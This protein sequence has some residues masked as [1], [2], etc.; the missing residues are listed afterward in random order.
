[1]LNML[2]VE[3]NMIYIKKLI[4][5]IL[6]NEENLRLLDV[7]TDGAEAL[8]ILT[9]NRIDIVLL[10]LKIPKIDGIELIKSLEKFNFDMYKQSIIVIN[11]DNIML[12]NIKQSSLVYSYKIKPIPPQNLLSDIESLISYKLLNQKDNNIDKKIMEELKYINYNS[13]HKGTTYI[14]ECI[15]I[16]YIQYN[17]EAENI[18]KQIYPILVKKYNKSESLIKNSI[19]KATDYMYNECE[20]KKLMK[21]F[22]CDEDYK[23]TPKKVI[24]TIIRKL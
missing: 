17:G 10:D 9:K 2:I 7:A 21:Y 23:P 12:Q 20:I 14:K 15:K 11:E 6:K 24:K 19:I 4:S 8:E 1:M 13:S 5:L 3:E 18:S 16:D 22:K